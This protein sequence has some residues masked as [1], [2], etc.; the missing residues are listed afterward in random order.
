MVAF[1]LRVERV[2][3]TH[4]RFGTHTNLDGVGMGEWVDVQGVHDSVLGRRCG[5]LG[6]LRR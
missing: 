5:V 2:S 6:A 3:L 1:K 4:Q